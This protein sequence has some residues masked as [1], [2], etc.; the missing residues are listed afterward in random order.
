MWKK[1]ELLDPPRQQRRA[2]LEVGPAHCCTVHSNKIGEKYA[3]DWHWANG[4]SLGSCIPAA[5]DNEHP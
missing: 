2:R 5:F 4:I 1:P 3:Y